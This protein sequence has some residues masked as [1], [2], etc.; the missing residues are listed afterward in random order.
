MPKDCSDDTYPGAAAT[1]EQT[2]ALARAYEAAAHA[3]LQDAKRG[4]LAAMPPYL[5]AL[6]AIELALNAYRRHQGEA[7]SM[8]R[9]R[10]HDMSPD[11]VVRKLGL[12]R[13][14]LDHLLDLTVQREYLLVR[15]APYRAVPRSQ[16][17]RITATLGEVV[18]KV[19]QR[20]EPSVRTE[21]PPPAHAPAD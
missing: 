20:I 7:P 3:L 14:T 6:Q 21:P 17:N 16:H 5:C 12:R 2:L 8:I 10:L 1:P 9:G 4:P 15:Y 11:D 18:R 13:R 19:A